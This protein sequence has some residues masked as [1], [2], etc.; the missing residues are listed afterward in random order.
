MMMYLELG[1]LSGQK[2]NTD[3]ALDYYLKGLQAAK[4]LNDKSRIQQFSNLILTYI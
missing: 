1:D 2:G 4:E 3:S